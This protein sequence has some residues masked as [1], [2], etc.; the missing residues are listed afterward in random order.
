MSTPDSTLRRSRKA[1]R[2]ERRTARASVVE[3]N[4]PY[5]ELLSQEGIAS[6]E[7]HA[8]WILQEFGIEFRGDDEALR[9]HTLVLYVRAG[10]L[11]A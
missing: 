4:I 3:C 6:I 1:R 5:Y 11:A 2:G 8:D 9:L 7:Q 10:F